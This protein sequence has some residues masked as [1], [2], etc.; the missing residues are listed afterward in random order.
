MNICHRHYKQVVM[1]NNNNN[2]NIVNNNNCNY[3]NYLNNFNSMLPSSTE[4]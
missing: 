4:R 3:L 1:D 2:I